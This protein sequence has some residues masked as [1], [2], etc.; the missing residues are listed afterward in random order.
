MKKDK[1]WLAPDQKYATC[2]EYL[3]DIGVCKMRNWVEKECKK[4]C[5]FCTVYEC[6][7][8]EFELAD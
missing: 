1:V 6:R 3:S 4:Y 7:A 8:D 5:Q 2:T